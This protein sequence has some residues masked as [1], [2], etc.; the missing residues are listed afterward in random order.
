MGV[1]K[2]TPKVDEALISGIARG[3]P[4][5]QI[6]RDLKIDRTI[7]YDWRKQDPDL[8][9]RIARARDIGFDAI[10]DDCLAI[11]DEKSDDPASRRVRVET[12]L[13]LLAKW[14][15]RRYGEKV[16]HTGADGTGPVSIET[17]RRTII[18]P[19]HGDSSKD[20]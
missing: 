15:P 14:D 19:G 9:Q 3:I 6:C 16:Q 17:I 1:T 20:A 10:A 2:R 11:A 7:V 4:L 18:D 12:R 8:D 5:A 13:K